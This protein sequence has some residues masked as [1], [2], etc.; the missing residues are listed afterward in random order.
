M[1]REYQKP[2][3]LVHTEGFMNK[4]GPASGSYKD[5]IDGVKVSALTRDFGSP[6]FV[7][8]EKTIREKYRKTI[9]EF[10]H[11]YPQVQFS[12]SY[13]TNYLDAICQI[14]HQEGSWAE[15]V[16]H[17][18]YEKAIRLGVP[19]EKII[20]NGPYKPYEALKFAVQRKSKI[21]VDNMEE[22]FN[23]EKLANE[24]QKPIDLGLRVNLDAGIYPAWTRFGFNL[25]N[26]AAFSAI[27]KIHSTGKLKLKGLHCH[28]GTFI[29]EPK[30]Y[31]TTVQKLALFSK[32]LKDELGIKI[33]YIDIGGGFPSSNTLHTQ[34][35]PGSQVNP[36]IE[37]FAEVICEE[38]LARTDCFASPPQL[39]L[40]TGRAL[41]DEAGYLVS[42]VVGSKR[43]TDGSPSLILDAGINLLFT[44][45]WYKHNIIPT[46]PHSE[47]LENITLFGPLCMNID[48]VRPSI[49]FPALSPGQQVLIHP[50]GAYNVT[51]W[52]QFIQYRPAVVLIDENEKVHQIRAKEDLEYITMLE[53]VPGHL[54]NKGKKSALNKSMT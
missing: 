7:F 36:P 27:T 22:I 43:L 18:E 48:I 25:E 11:K 2:R 12:W 8:S 19:G 29:L 30:A 14:F 1:K 20:F 49:Q 41:I 21:N 24:L 46:Q 47:F 35:L 50:V 32:K 5:S 17:F 23:M 54:Q 51:Q 31:K 16:S 52:M 45:T 33:E 6:L 13:K 39:I 42:T 53:S 10:S 40:E 38:L 4:F 15:V 9:G 26:Q 44:S 3:I 34:Y 37:K 28:I